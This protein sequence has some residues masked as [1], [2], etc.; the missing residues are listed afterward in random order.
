[1][2]APQKSIFLYNNSFNL[3]TPSIQ[4]WWSALTSHLFSEWANVNDELS[5]F[6]IALTLNSLK[7]SYLGSRKPAIFSSS[8]RVCLMSYIEAIFSDQ[9]PIVQSTWGSNICPPEPDPAKIFAKLAIPGTATVTKSDI[10]DE[11]AHLYLGQTGTARATDFVKTFLKDVIAMGKVREKFVNAQYTFLLGIAKKGDLT[12]QFSS[13]AIQ[14]LQTALGL[15]NIELYKEELSWCAHWALRNI[16]YTE[17][18]QWERLFDLIMKAS[19]NVE[20]R[21]N[22]FQLPSSE[23]TPWLLQPHQGN[24]SRS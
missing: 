19:A 17:S 22:R 24:M 3:L 14:G 2:A 6:A 18:D 5:R 8:E 4:D 16:G 20:R 1:M 12:N 13:K 10:W 23:A 9:A 7:A 21:F 11:L 15:E